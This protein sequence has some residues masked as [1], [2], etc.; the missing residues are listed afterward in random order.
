MLPCVWYHGGVFKK[1][2]NRNLHRS[3]VLAKGGQSLIYVHLFAKQDKA[4]ITRADL[5][6]FRKLATIYAALTD[7]QLRDGVAPQ[8]LT[9]DLPIRRDVLSK[10]TLDDLTRIFGVEMATRAFAAQDGQWVGPH[11]TVRGQHWL[12]VTERTASVAPT[13]EAVREQVRLDWV[14]DHEQARLEQRVSELRGTYVIEF[15]G[16]GKAP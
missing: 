3:I 6:A 4:N 9:S 11:H 16:E 2:L 10:V 5:A 1:R 8:Q 15:T 7:N 13:L 14:N 12:R